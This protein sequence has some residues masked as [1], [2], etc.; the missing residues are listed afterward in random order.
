MAGSDLSTANLPILTNKNWTRWSTQMRVRSSFKKRGE[1][2][3]VKLQTLRRQY[4]L[5][6][7]EDSD[8]VGE[9][10]NKIITITNQMK[11]CGEVV[12]DTMIIEKIMRSLPR[13][14]D[15][16]VVAIEESKDLSK[17]KVEELQSS[18]EA[19]EMRMAD[20]NP[21]KNDEQ[22]LKVH[23]FKHDEKKK[24]KKWKGKRSKGNW[25]FDK[26]KT[27]NGSTSM[28]KGGKEEKSHHS[29]K[30][31]R[32]I[33]CFNCNKYGHFASECHA[34]EGKQKQYQSKEANVAQENSDSEP[35]T[36]M[37]TTSGKGSHS[38]NDMWYL[39]SGCSNHRHVIWTG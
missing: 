2:Q 11:G 25:K 1:D 29:K 14:F 33:K 21:A 10:F 28:E 39:D 12:N 16:I 18:L 26:D 37:V 24:T 22:A 34:D 6:Q 15:Y 8:R 19:H 27:E 23:H 38:Q 3:E 31:K 5:L 4:E 36:L 13:K 17:M 32:N 35:L 30:D 9:Y 20:R 7:M